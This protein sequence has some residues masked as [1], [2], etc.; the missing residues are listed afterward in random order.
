[1]SD[2]GHFR[3]FEQAPPTSAVPPRA[4]ICLRCN[5]CRDGPIADIKEL[6][7]HQKKNPG[8]FPG[9]CDREV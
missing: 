1:M 5:I 7:S 2:L 3:R 4:D 8:T 9:L 6:G